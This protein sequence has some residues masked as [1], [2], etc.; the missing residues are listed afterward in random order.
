MPGYNHVVLVGNLIKDPIFFMS[1]K[2]VPVCKLIV[3]TNDR[4]GTDHAYFATVVASHK[5]AELL[6]KYAKRGMA[7]LVEGTLRG[8]NYIDNY[9]K[10]Q[11]KT[12]IHAKSVQFLDGNKN[13]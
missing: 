13:G 10:T 7:I 8:A 9:G 5:L 3:A 1:E 12:Q 6:E 4:A 11:T 2:N